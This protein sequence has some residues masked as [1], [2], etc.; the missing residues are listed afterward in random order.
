MKRSILIGAGVVALVLMLAGAAFVAGRLLSTSGQV[1]GAASGP[2]IIVPGAGG[3]MIEAQFEQADEL[4]DERPDVAGFFARREDN[5]VFV[6]E[7]SG[8]GMMIRVGEDG[9]VSTNAGD[10]ETEVVI[11]SD[12]LVY[13]DVTTEI[14]DESHDGGTVKQVLESGSVDEVGE[15]SVVMVWGEKR[16]DR[17]VADTLL[18]TP[19]PVIQR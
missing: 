5:S 7:S 18:Y 3:D 1:G 11:T 2:R 10:K 9:A 12:T 6:S 13:V 17:V 15:Y 8:D 19:P 16:G 14:V 4:P